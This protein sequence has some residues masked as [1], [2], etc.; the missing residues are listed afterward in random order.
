MNASLRLTLLGGCVLVAALV[1]PHS[2][3]VVTEDLL[4][5]YASN[6]ADE[7]ALDLAHYEAVDS[8]EDTTGDADGDADPESAHDAP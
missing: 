7:P 2:A 3:R 6:G 8:I 1:S 4:G 5:P